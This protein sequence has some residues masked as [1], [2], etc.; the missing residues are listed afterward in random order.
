VTTA[1]PWHSNFLDKETFSY[2]SYLIFVQKKKLILSPKL[3]HFIAFIS[4]FLFLKLI[5]YNFI[6]QD[7]YN[8]LLNRFNS[9]YLNTKQFM[10][11]HCLL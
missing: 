6:I 8:Y 9:V 10:Y 4:Y 7:S 11:S 2:A 3:T 1:L 5:S